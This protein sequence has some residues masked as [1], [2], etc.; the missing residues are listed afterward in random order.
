[1]GS[2]RGVY[3][4][5]LKLAQDI[6][7]TFSA[8]FLLVKVVTHFLPTIRIEGPFEL[9]VL[10]VVSIVLVLAKEAWRPSRIEVPI[11]N[12]NTVIEVI[13][14]D[15][16]S[17]DGIRVIPVNE[18]FDSKL[19][20]PVSDQSL[21][22]ILLR[23]CFGGHPEAFDK[24]LDEQLRGK[25]GCEVERVEGKSKRYPIGSTALINV[26]Q[27]RYIT[28][29]S[30]RTDPDTCKASSDVGLMWVAL[31]ELWQRLRIEA[32]GYA[33]NL[34]LVGSGLAGIGLPTRNLLDVMILS[35]I[36]ETKVKEVTARIRIVLHRD[37][38]DDLDLRDVR[39]YWKR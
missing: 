2:L 14:G 9:T 18:F 29:A 17:Q 10:V 20:K 30:A 32:N 35:A 15:L 13:F 31:R 7:T 11:A 5:P 34:P 8:L 22:G 23:K 36:A 24:Q 26:N 3:R 6:F 39:H 12:C 16:F 21:H 25:E 1:M 37:R 4:H 27:D 33:V 38:F 28:F 19:G